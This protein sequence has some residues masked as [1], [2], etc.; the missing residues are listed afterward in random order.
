VP[1]DEALGVDGRIRTVAVDEQIAVMGLAMPFDGAARALEKIG[2]LR[3]SASTVEE[4]TEA[5]GRR[6]QERAHQGAKQA[7]K[8]ALPAAGAVLD[9]FSG[10]LP[11]LYI[12]PDGTMAP[13]RKADR[14]QQAPTE[15]HPA[16]HREVKVGV[17][18][19]QKDIMNI[20]PKRRE[21]RRKT[22]VATMGGLQEFGDELWS[23]V[24][25]VAG[26][27][28]CQMV[29][30]GDGADWID[31]LKDEHF[32]DAIRILD[33]Y[34]PLERLWGV[35]N[36]LYGQKSFEARRWVK[37]QETRLK[38]SELDAVLAELRHLES[39][40]PFRQG[41]EKTLREKAAEHRKYFTKRRHLMDY[42]RYLNLGLMI[43]SGVIESSNKRVVGLRLKQCG[44]HWSKRGADAVAHIRALY[45]SDG[46]GWDLLWA[47]LGATA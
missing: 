23:A 40:K 13:M 2:G 42:A 5:A 17:V 38:A 8:I 36:L 24:I 18:F 37:E 7:K 14:P 21:I 39:A 10:S 25:Q 30:I 19:W 3:V 31:S 35:A 43:G 45:L 22:Y 1:I 6:A 16:T 20:S 9:R 34:H 28:R 12:E 4:V 33:F 44:M 41:D 46:S 15:E 27:V 26:T 47:S 32:P 11:I 29:L